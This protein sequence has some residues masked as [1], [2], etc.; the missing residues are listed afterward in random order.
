MRCHL[1]H[2]YVLTWLHIVMIAVLAVTGFYILL[3]A[4]SAIG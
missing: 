4:L 1:C 2:R 3:E